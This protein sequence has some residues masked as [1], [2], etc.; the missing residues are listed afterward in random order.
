VSGGPECT[1]SARR[2]APPLVGITDRIDV[3]F[4][5]DAARNLVDSDAEPMN[6]VTYLLIDR[7]GKF[8]P[9]F[10]NVLKQGGVKVKLTPARSTNCN[11]IC[12]RFV[13]TLRRELLDRVIFFGGPSRRS[14]M[15]E[16]VRHY[17]SERTHQS[18]ENAILEPGVEVARVTGTI[19][20]RDRLGGIP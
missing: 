19:K 13:G 9:A 6:G 11:A 8:T 16:S 17:H 1:A 7:D 15:N 18:F 12:E 2:A 14:V 4:S 10:K 5:T 20:R 3:E